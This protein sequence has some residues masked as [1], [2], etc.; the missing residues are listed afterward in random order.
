VVPATEGLTPNKPLVVE[1]KSGKQPGPDRDSLRQLDDWVFDLS[2]EEEIRKGRVRINMHWAHGAPM[3]WPRTH[4]PTPHK[5]VLIYNG[6]AG[7]PFSSRP[8][9]WLGE[10][11]RIFAEKRDFCII[12]LPCLL[13]WHER[14]RSD[15]STA[16]AFWKATHTACGL[17]GW[18]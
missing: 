11:E 2:Q 7:T 9:K 16:A 5:G 15:S 6:P 13:A 10:N 8:E 3:F 4:H 12:A 1:V 14:A 18:P 17:L